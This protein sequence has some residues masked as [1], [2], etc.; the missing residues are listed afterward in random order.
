[1]RVQRVARCGAA[2]SKYFGNFN[3]FDH[4]M[5][6]HKEARE[7]LKEEVKELVLRDPGRMADRVQIVLEAVREI[8]EE[9]NV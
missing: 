3:Q 5:K 2:D 1:M 8:K 9:Y 4:D 7:K 6:K